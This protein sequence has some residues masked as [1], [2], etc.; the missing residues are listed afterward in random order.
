[1]LKEVRNSKRN[2]PFYESYG[3]LKTLSFMR[4]IPEGLVQYFPTHQAGIIL[5]T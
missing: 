4:E 1:M 5:V 2:F 3:N